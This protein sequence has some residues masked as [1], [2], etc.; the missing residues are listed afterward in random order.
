MEVNSTVSI[1]RTLIIIFGAFRT[2]DRTCLSIA[3]N[4]IQPNLPNVRILLSFDQDSS[5]LLPES[6]S[7]CL[8]PYIDTVTV[9][10]TRQKS[11]TVHA[12]LEFLLITRALDYIESEKETF[13]FM[14]K[15]RADLQCNVEI[16]PLPYIFGLPSS[17]KQIISKKLE[18]KLRLEAFIGLTKDVYNRR[19]QREPTIV[20]LIRAFV[21]SAGIPQFV[22]LMIFSPMHSPW[23]MGHASFLRQDLED[24]LKKATDEIIG[25]KYL[26]YIRKLFR[27]MVYYVNSNLPYALN[28]V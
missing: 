1:A 4:I 26:K 3:H 23:S 5:T 19:V 12:N 14:I 22:E 9:L 18:Y 25:A 21:L 16:P 27:S 7:D 2:F 20:E 17:T 6:I 11:G 24:T 8:D 10:S 13:D 28:Y 15:V